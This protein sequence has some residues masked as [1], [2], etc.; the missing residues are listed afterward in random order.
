MPQK[1]VENQEL[2]LQQQQRL[3]ARQMQ[4]VKLLEMPLAALEEA[5]KTEIDDNPALEPSSVDDALNEDHGDDFDSREENFEEQQEREEREEALDAALEGI[6]RDDEMPATFAD[7]A[8]DYS[9]ADYEEMV[10]G[11]TVSFYDKINEQMGEL[12]LTPWQRDIMEYLIGS[13][14]SDGLLRKPIEDIV[15]ELAFRQYIDTNNEEVQEMLKTL[16]GFDPPGIGARSLQ[17]CLLIQLDRR[18]PSKT[19]ELA[20]SVLEKQ[21]DAFTR[22]NWDR[23]RQA[24]HLN[25]YQ[26]EDARK[27]IRRLNPKPGAA[28]G[29]TLGRSTQQ[30]TPD[31]IVDTSDD[32][33]VTFTLNRGQ[34]PELK[35]SSSFTEMVDA[36]NKNPKGMSRAEK[37]ALLYAKEKVDKAQ[38]FIDAVKQRRQTLYV[39]MKAIISWQRRFF[40][41]GDEAD[42][43]PMILK[44]IA[45]KTGLDISTISRVANEKYAQTRWGTYPLK[46]FFSNEYTTNDGEE[47]SVRK[48]RLALKDI[49]DHEDKHKPYS[50]EELTKKMEQ[51]GLPVAR[52]TVAKYRQLMGIPVAR[53]R[54]K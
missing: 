9:Q 48:L 22:N 45:E 47:M 28:L 46:Y 7:N 15:D 21:F 54:K 6:G 13:L 40:K 29:E 34:L 10:Y 5:V 38:G 1:I 51:E 3:T 36:Y 33:T 30:I 35:V 37:E 16:Q 27:E 50:D 19:V 42:L 20:R 4:F 43:K 23:I 18:P 49:I 44:D 12:D 11:D 53:M 8:S 32:G 52:R 17:E 25:D 14:D 39:T 41:D 24:L 26:A 31:F 2:A